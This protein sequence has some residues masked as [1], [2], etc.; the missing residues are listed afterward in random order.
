VWGGAGLIRG[1]WLLVVAIVAGLVGMHHFVAGHTG[2]GMP[3]AVATGPQATLMG[4]TPAGR[5]HVGRV[6]IHPV[7]AR[8]VSTSAGMS[9]PDC[10]GSMDMMGQCCLAVLTAVTVLAAA[11]MVA[12]AWRRVGE[13]GYLLVALSALGARGPPTGCARFTQ[14]CVLRR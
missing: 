10:C 13:P 14:L 2:H 7:E 9:P 5:S 11:L 12:V 3:M 6:G 4:A 1:Q 8:L